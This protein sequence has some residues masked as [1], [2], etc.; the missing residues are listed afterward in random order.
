LKSER[1]EQCRAAINRPALSFAVK[2]PWV[3]QRSNAEHES[4]R[5][6]MHLPEKGMGHPFPFV[7]IFLDS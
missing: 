4:T 5:I 3:M 2:S 1:T 7:T 6:K